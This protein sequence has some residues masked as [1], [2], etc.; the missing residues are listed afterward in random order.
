MGLQRHHSLFLDSMDG[1][2]NHLPRGYTP[3][4]AQVVI[5]Q[6]VGPQGGINHPHLHCLV[7]DPEICPQNEPPEQTET[8]PT[9]TGCAGRSLC[10]STFPIGSD[11]CGRLI[12][13]LGRSG[14]EELSPK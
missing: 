4:Q 1:T 6:E 10:P 3:G 11:R 8:V 14:G 2:D 5:Y 12:C 7:L 13:I 9:P